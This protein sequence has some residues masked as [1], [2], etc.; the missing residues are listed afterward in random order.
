MNINYNVT[1]TQIPNLTVASVQVP[2]LTP[3]Q[4]YLGRWNQI[5]M[6]FSKR[7]DVKKTK[8]SAQMDIFNLLNGNSILSVNETYGS[9]LNRPAS[10]LQ[11]RLIAA[12]MQLTF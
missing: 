9:Q 6:R 8:I 10:I 4:S 5:D 7:F 3:G 1:R 2:L 11:G 12:G